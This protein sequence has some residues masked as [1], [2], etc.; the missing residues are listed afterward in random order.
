MAPK[1][2]RRYNCHHHSPFPSQLPVPLT[3]TLTGSSFAVGDSPSAVFAR[4]ALG[5]V[6]ITVVQHVEAAGAVATGIGVAPGDMEKKCVQVP[7]FKDDRDTVY[8]PV[9]SVCT[10]LLVSHLILD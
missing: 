8:T 3:L 5:T 6:A 4:K 7:F 9:F 2:I 10:I 1:T